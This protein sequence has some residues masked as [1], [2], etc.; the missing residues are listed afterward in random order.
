MNKITTRL[1][2]VIALT[3]LALALGYTTYGA[4][5]VTKNISSAGSVT[6]SANLGVYSDSNCQTPLTTIDWGTLSPGGSVTKTVYIKNTG[7][8][9][10]L[11]LNM[12][13]SNWSPANVNNYLTL[14][15]NPTSATLG[16]GA[17]TAA[18]IT[19]TVSS[20]ITDVT[21]FS[22]QI[23]ISGSQ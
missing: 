19:L 15:W 16:P 10:S 2:A 21:N 17:S 20:T 1:I 22:V 14:T 3:T 12:T 23:N 7:S 13:P 8:G 4:I 9:V 6:V 5:T 11:N 18:T